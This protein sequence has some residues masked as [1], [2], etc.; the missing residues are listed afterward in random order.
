M[1]GWEKPHNFFLSCFLCNCVYLYAGLQAPWASLVAFFTQS[2]LAD[3]LRKNVPFGI[4]VNLQG[5]LKSFSTADFCP[6]AALCDALTI[7]K[8][9]GKIKK[10]GEIKKKV[11]NN[12]YILTPEIIPRRAC[13]AG[14]CRAEQSELRLGMARR[15]QSS[16]TVFYLF[17]TSN[18]KQPWRGAGNRSFKRWKA[19]SVFSTQHFAGGT[20]G[21]SSA[22]LRRSVLLQP[23]QL[24]MFLSQRPQ[25]WPRGDGHSF[26]QASPSPKVNF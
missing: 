11:K 9:N 16:C 17:E 1:G 20:H 4:K 12:I 5:D 18:R 22:Q 2:S 19:L 26:C 7:Y 6:V 21:F 23:L 10:K 25:C 13:S 14:W 24:Q 3:V 8:W 15:K